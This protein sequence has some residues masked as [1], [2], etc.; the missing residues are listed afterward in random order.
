MG[1]YSLSRYIGQRLLTLTN[2]GMCGPLILFLGRYPAF[3]RFKI[4]MA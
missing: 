1:L 2:V 3:N 4:G